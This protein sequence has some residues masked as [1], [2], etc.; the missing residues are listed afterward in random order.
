MT[1]QRR[2]ELPHI[3]LKIKQKLMQSMLKRDAGRK[4]Y[5]LP[6]TGRVEMDDA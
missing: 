6:L 1:D 2:S 5:Q 3:R 4:L